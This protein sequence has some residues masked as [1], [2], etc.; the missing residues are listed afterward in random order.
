MLSH[1]FFRRSQVAENHQRDAEYRGYQR[2][3][4]RI[5]VEYSVSVSD[6]PDKNEQASEPNCV[7]GHGHLFNFAITIQELEAR[8]SSI[9][10]AIVFFKC[11]V[12]KS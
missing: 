3:Q 7:S 2:R 6:D 10:P 1:R 12:T 4:A 8:M 5:A 11:S 9:M